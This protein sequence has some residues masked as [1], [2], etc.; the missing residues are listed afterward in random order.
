MNGCMVHVSITSPQA[1]PSFLGSEPQ[2][3]QVVNFWWINVQLFKELACLQTNRKQQKT[4]T[5]VATSKLSNAKPKVRPQRE[6]LHVWFW[7]KGAC[8]TNRNENRQYHLCLHN[9]Q[10]SITRQAECCRRVWA[11]VTHSLSSAGCSGD[12]CNPSNQKMKAIWAAHTAYLK[13]K[14]KKIH[15]SEL[16]TATIALPFSCVA[17]WSWCQLHTVSSSCKGLLWLP[18]PCTSRN[19]ACPAHLKMLDSRTE[20]LPNKP[21]AILKCPYCSILPE[22]SQI[23]VLTL[24][25]GED[26]REVQGP[27]GSVWARP[28]STPLPTHRAQ[29]RADSAALLTLL[30]Y[31]RASS[32]FP[33]W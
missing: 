7:L 19:K 29:G 31:S 32:P 26:G 20:T 12:A 5:I 10:Y 25:V 21:T 14:R 17:W 8:L 3:Q 4:H 27:E 9:L 28:Q 1:E 22:P 11:T 6:L 15:G 24:C 30:R 2:L 33:L 23:Q 18:G 13:T 16:Y